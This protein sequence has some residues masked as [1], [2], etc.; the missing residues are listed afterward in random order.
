M[1]SKVI[2]DY[3]MTGTKN[4]LLTCVGRRSYIVDFFKAEVGSSGRIVG[5]NS[6]Q[7]TAGMVRCDRA[8]VVPEA[9]HPTY[10]SS[11]LKICRRE[12]INVVVPLFDYDLKAL[13]MSRDLFETLGIDLWVSRPEALD[14]AE[15]KILTA[16][17][18]GALGIRTPPSARTVSEMEVMV[19]NRDLTFPVIIKPRN[20]TGSL[21]T[22]VA[23]N[24]AD[25]TCLYEYC[26]K[27]LDETY[28]P[29]K[30]D[31]PEVIIQ[32]YKKG[33]EYGIDVFNS[34]DMNPRAMCIKRKLEMRS[35]ETDSA[36]TVR[37]NR[38]EE[39]ALLI[40]QNLRHTGCLDL[41]VIATDS[42]L[43][44]LDMN[45]RFGGGYP[46]THLA[47]LNFVSLIVQDRAKESEPNAI[48]VCPA[49]KM[50]RKFIVPRSINSQNPVPTE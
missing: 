6:I 4:I 37:D 48:E 11:L 10:I 19:E 22:F 42:E 2:Y 5:V 34:L 14:I 39:L 50:A 38:L 31:E 15:D 28:I 40:A 33:I 16:S 36:V 35:G 41:D 8:Y 18:C 3:L 23:D 21:L 17:F 29:S 24:L 44:V 45:L 43:H 9:S 25:A 27:K 26:A 13:A 1:T 47:G 7:N 20:G 30:K 49:N 12:S 32:E 46:F